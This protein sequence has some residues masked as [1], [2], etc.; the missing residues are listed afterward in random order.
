[1]FVN[2]SKNVIRKDCVLGSE[3]FK[4]CQTKKLCVWIVNP[5]EKKAVFFVQTTSRTAVLNEKNYIYKT[6]ELYIVKYSSKDWR[7]SVITNWNT[8]LYSISPCY[9]LPNILTVMLSATILSFFTNKKKINAK[10]NF[11]MWL[12]N[13][14]KNQIH[15]YTKEIGKSFL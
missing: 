8:I 1:M 14:K 6:I 12:I 9:W 11:F 10:N 7:I 2:K 3:E 15:R 5:N 4:W 13:E